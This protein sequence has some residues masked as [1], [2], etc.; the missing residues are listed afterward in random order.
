LVQAGDGS[1]IRGGIG[2]GAGFTHHAVLYVGVADI[3][4]ALRRA[5]ELGT[6]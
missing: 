3:E 2:G 1:G 5:E 4:A 6:A